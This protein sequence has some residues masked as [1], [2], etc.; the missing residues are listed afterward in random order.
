MSDYWRFV[1]SE[2]K[3]L[4]Y[5]VSLA[6]FSSF[7]Q[8]FLISLFVPFFLVEFGLSHADFGILYA[9]A[10]LGSALLL[11]WT[12]QWL[13]RTR[14]TRF[15]FAVVSL[16]ACSAFLLAVAGHVAVL[17]L[18]LLGLRL[19]GQGLSSHTAL[20]SMARY[21]GVRRGTALGV[22]GLGFPA[23]EAV[24]PLLV[25]GSIALVGWRLS[26]TAVGLLALC[27]FAPLLH[28][29]LTRAGVELDPRAVARKRPAPGNFGEGVSLRE[30]APPTGERG[31]EAR[32]SKAGSRE[33]K[34]REAQGR[35]APVPEAPNHRQ[36]GWTR[37]QVLRD[38]RF[39]FVLPL[40][41]LPPFWTTGLFLYQTSIAELKGWSLTLM[42]SSFMA[43]ALAR[44]ASSLLAGGVVDRF[45]ARHLLPFSTVPMGVG[46]GVLM[47]SGGPWAAYAVMACLGITMGMSATVKSALWAE[48]YG[49]GHLGAIKSMMASLMVVS[50]AASPV[51]VGTIL[52]AGG[53]L[54]LVLWVGILSVII[55]TALASRIFPDRSGSAPAGVVWR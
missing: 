4:G 24:L 10:T 45:S 34:S 36:E 29:L 42:A 48:L 25:A 32:G 11:P 8:T 5:G 26:W 38:P 54:A 35:E 2:S 27:L 43:F 18:A 12:G 6:F 55:A 23:G 52:D 46:L 30:S 22:S 13:D 9:S 7:G 40:A 39:W 15:T 21:F 14:L 1:R 49:L 19:A 33:G 3:L 53:G 50:T 51:L 20:T 41:L 47:A 16:M 28:V 44:V 37:A 17:C 31:P